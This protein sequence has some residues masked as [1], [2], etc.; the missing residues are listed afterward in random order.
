MISPGVLILGA[1]LCRNICC[2]TSSLPIIS[3]NCCHH[4]WL[5]RES[6]TTLDWV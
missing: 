2:W 5:L 3:F 1:F 4:V 6:T